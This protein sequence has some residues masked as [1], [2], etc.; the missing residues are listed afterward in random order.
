MSSNITPIRPFSQPDPQFY[1]EEMEQLFIGSLFLKP[2]NIITL[3]VDPDWFAFDVHSGIVIDMMRLY[4]SDMPVKPST[5]AVDTIYGLEALGG[6]AYCAG[7]VAGVVTTIGMDGH[8]NYL[9]SLYQ[10]RVAIQAVTDF[11]FTLANPK[12]NFQEALNVLLATMSE[13]DSGLVIKTHQDILNEIRKELTEPKKCYQTGFVEL[14]K[15]MGGGLYEGFTYG[16]VGAEKMGKTTMAHSISYQLTVPHAYVALE[17]GSKQ[18]EQKNV[19]REIG[20]N[21]MAFLSNSRQSLIK[22]MTPVQTNP[23]RFY[24]DAPSASWDEIRFALRRAKLIHGIKGFI[25][26][27]WQLVGGKQK[28]ETEEKHLRTVAQECADFARKENLFCIL[29]AQAGKDGE[30]FAGSGLKKACD[31]ILYLRQPE[32]DE[33]KRWLHM[34]A[35]RYTQRKDIGS[36]QDPSFRMEVKKGPYF[37][38]IE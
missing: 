4:R 27:Y 34:G 11:Q 13:S 36:A 17:M 22:S 37:E 3:D 29:M 1:D 10:K 19:A 24:V 7:C 21:S 28:N 35:A 2:D 26:D 6:K 8:A 12:A 16:L 31:M 23:N 5:I 33:S 32:N 14:D 20:V 18:I 38:E 9:K 30:V 15:A 25:V